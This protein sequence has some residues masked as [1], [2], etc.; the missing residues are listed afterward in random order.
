MLV[1][2]IYGSVY[3]VKKNTEVLIFASKDNGLNVNVYKSKYTVITRNQNARRIQN[4]K[5]DNISNI[6][7]KP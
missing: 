4:I 3:T 7:R 5:T 1:M 6:W 2:L